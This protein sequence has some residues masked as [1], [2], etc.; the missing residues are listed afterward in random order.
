VLPLY[1]P[2][3]WLGTTLPALCPP[4]PVYDDVHGWNT[5]Q[6]LGQDEFHLA[7]SILWS[8]WRREARTRRTSTAWSRTRSDTCGSPWPWGRTS[9]ATP[10]WTKGSTPSWTPS[11]SRTTGSGTILPPGEA[12]HGSW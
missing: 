7:R 12:R 1:S 5:D 9:G 11:R 8:R 2:P 4:L 3:F 10:G 6:Y